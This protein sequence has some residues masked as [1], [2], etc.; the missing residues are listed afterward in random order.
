VNPDHLLRFVIEPCLR[1]LAAHN[2]RLDGVVVRSLLLG[3]AMVES[4]LRHLQQTPAGPAVGLWQVEPRTHDDCWRNWLAFRP[5]EHALFRSLCV[6][7]P[8]ADEMRWN[9]RYGCAVARLVY[10]RA[11]E[12]LPEQLDAMALAGYHK[13]IFNTAAG[14]TDVTK[15]VGDFA[16]AIRVVQ[17]G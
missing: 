15:S 7:E 8:S 4:G 6:D 5:L 9:L 14:A 2:P 12:R 10:W 1:L 3:T 17:A 11:R 13:R 16:R